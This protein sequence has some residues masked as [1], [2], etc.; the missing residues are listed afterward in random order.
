MSKK[1]KVAIIDS[2]I[3][4]STNYQISESIHYYVIGED[5]ITNQYNIRSPLK[6]PRTILKKS[7]NAV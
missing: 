5:I 1:I 2:G 6:I 3:L 7:Q 4:G